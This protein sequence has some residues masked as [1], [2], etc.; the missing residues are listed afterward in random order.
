[1]TDEFVNLSSLPLIDTFDESTDALLISEHS[2]YNYSSFNSKYV[3]MKLFLDTMFDEVYKLVDFRSMAYEN[4]AIYAPSDHNHGNMYTKIS[5]IVYD[6]TPLKYQRNDL[7]SVGNFVIDGK[8]QTV[9]APLSC[10]QTIIDIPE[11]LAHPNIGQIKMVYKPRL[12]QINIESESFDGWLYPDGSIYNKDNFE[13]GDKLLSLFPYSPTQFKMPIINQFIKFS[14]QTGN[15]TSE[16]GRTV[17]APHNHKINFNLNGSVTIN[18]QISCGSSFGHLQANSASYTHKGNFTHK[19]TI[20]QG[21]VP[22]SINVDVSIPNLAGKIYTSGT[23]NPTTN[24]S[25][26]SHFYLPIMIYVGKT[27]KARIS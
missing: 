18:A 12:D 10:S 15:I 22:N 25:Y 17:I 7:L 11:R 27:N 20:I 8:W 9:Y 19:Y 1:M 16:T 24:I 4:S 14:N 23:T 5:S 3:G 13:N 2:I 26:P 6:F 21:S